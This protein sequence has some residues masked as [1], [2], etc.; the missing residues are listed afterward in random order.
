MLNRPNGDGHSSHRT[1]NV[2][3]TITL[4]NSG[5]AKLIGVGYEDE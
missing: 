3:V 5:S 2:K 1:S 4:A